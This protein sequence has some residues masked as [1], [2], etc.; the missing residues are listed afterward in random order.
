MNLTILC[1][2]PSKTI[3]QTCISSSLALFWNICDVIMQ[4]VYILPFHI[5]LTN[6]KF[7]PSNFVLN[8]LLKAI[9]L[10]CSVPKHNIISRILDFYS[11]FYVT[12]PNFQSSVYVYG[13]ALTLL[14]LLIMCLLD[15]SNCPESTFISY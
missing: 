8:Q 1:I 11:L 9:I 3:V 14:R 7:C 6:R 2:T 15:Y 12:I 5:V 13:C 10:T 4:R